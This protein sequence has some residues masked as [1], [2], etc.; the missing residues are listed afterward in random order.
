MDNLPQLLC[1]PPLQKM[2]EPLVRL[3]LK[4]FL[5]VLTAQQPPL[6]LDLA[7]ALRVRRHI[8]PLQLQMVDLHV[9]IL[10]RLQ[11]HVMIAR[12]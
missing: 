8:S 12:P 3:P 9:R 10:P 5:H 2:A 6:K 11:M 7:M 1:S 4:L